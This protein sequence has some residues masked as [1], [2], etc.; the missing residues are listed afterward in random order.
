MHLIKYV[1]GLHEKKCKTLM[2]EIKNNYKH[3]QTIPVYG[4]EDIVKRPIVPKFIYSLY[5]FPIKIPRIFIQFIWKRKIQN[6]F[7]ND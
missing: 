4:Q 2:E 5:A 6:N 3:R 1:Q 7:H